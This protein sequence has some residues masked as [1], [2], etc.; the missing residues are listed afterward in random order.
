[1]IAGASGKSKIVAVAEIARGRVG[2]VEA[3]RQGA[4]PEVVFGAMVNVM[5]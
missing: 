3:R 1:M 5:A 2:C 4:V